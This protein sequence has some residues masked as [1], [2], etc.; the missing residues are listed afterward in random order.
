[1]GSRVRGNQARK[2][3][4]AKEKDPSQKVNG[5]AASIETRPAFHSDLEWNAPAP[6]FGSDGR[7]VMSYGTGS[8]EQL[9]GFRRVDNLLNGLQACCRALD[10]DDGETAVQVYLHLAPSLAEITLED[11]RALARQGFTPTVVNGIA[12]RCRE[13]RMAEAAKEYV[14]MPEPVQKCCTDRDKAAQGFT[15]RWPKP[16]ETTA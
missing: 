1:M 3:V 6:V 7:S 5:S 10:R 11:S 2:D 13:A 8:E 4:K 12:D 16:V 14:C 15:P 9:N